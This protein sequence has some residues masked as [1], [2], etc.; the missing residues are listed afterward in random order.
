MS[1]YLCKC[2]SKLIC[3]EASSDDDELSKWVLEI[4]YFSM[5]DDI[6]ISDSGD[7]YALRSRSCSD[8]YLLSMEPMP[9]DFDFTTRDHPSLSG[10]KCRPK[11]LDISGFF[12]RTYELSSLCH[13]G[14]ALLIVTSLFPR[15][16][17]SLRR[18]ASRVRT[19]T[20]DTLTLDERYTLPES[21]KSR[22]KSE[23]CRSCS[24]DDDIESILHGVL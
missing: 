3:Y 11:L 24:D 10:E 21:S 23:S 14:V 15:K 12:M 17:K 6:A 5:C 1:P 2:L 19:V 16:K 4:E 7:R 18:D 22:H 8:I 9:C 20:S 13:I